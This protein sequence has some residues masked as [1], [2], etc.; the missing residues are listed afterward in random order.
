M[1]TRFIKESIW[2]SPNLNK[3]SPLAERHFY[4]LL[5]LPDDHGCFEATPAVI[6]GKCYPLQDVEIADIQ[7]WHDELRANDLVCFWEQNDRFYGIFKTWAKHNRI[8]SLHQRKTPPP[9]KDLSSLVV[10]RRHSHL[11][12]TPT[13]TPTHSL[14]KLKRDGQTEFDPLF[15]TFWKTYPLNIDKK[16]SRGLF[17]ALAEKGFADDVIKAAKGYVGFLKHQ[18]IHEN[19]EQKPMHPP[20]FL[21]KEAW[22]D[23]LDFEYKPPM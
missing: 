11:T 21:T 22:K 8:R 18:R 16:E 17:L 1:P 13:L 12:L 19:F 7:K 15:E 10:N 23:Y 3:L 5:P 4:R 6:K 14:R 20:K 2:T 9:P